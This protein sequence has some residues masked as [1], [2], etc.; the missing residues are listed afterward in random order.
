ML[1]IAAA[2]GKHAVVQTL[3]DIINSSSDQDE[4]LAYRLQV[5]L[6]KIGMAYWNFE[7]LH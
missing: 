4:I 2:L 1:D 3:I 5:K 7:K 6:S